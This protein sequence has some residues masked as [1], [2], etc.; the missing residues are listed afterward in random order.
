VHCGICDIVCPDLCF[1]WSQD[2][3]G[4]PT[5]RLLGI[6]YHYCKGCLKCVDACPA[7]AVS[8]LREQD[9]WAERHRVPLFGRRD[10]RGAE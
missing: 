6:G 2:G 10:E 9:G 4:E 8:E 1:V 3:E 5:V 7:G